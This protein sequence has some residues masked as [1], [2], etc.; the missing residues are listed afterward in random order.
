MTI[1]KL[2]SALTPKAGVLAL[3]SNAVSRDPKVVADYLADP[4]V[5][6]G[7]IG[8]RLALEMLNTM[9]L[10]QTQAAKINL[11]MLIL[12]GDQ[13]TLA[14]PEGSK[15]LDASISSTDKTLKILPGLFHEIFNEPER[16]AVLTNMT[17]WIADHLS[18]VAV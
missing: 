14:A 16:D 7:K 9:T 10:V 4:L 2:I 5:Y 3:D 8:A 1:S 13:D 18:A 12:H 15:I 17:D 11:P 6:N